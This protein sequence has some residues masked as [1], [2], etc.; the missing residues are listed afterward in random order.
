MHAH[1]CTYACVHGICGTCP[2]AYIDICTDSTPVT[3]YG[4]LRFIH[5]Q[6]ILIRLIGLAETSSGY[7]YLLSHVICGRGYTCHT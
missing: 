1:T 2:T 4:E 7:N 5:V 3:P 6:I